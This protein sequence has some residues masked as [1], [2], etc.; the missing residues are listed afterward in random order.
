MTLT[1]NDIQEAL[2]TEPTVRCMGPGPTICLRPKPMQR[3]G[4]STHD[5]IPEQRCAKPRLNESMLQSPMQSCT[6]SN[7]MRQANPD[8]FRLQYMRSMLLV[9]PSGLYGS[10]PP[11]T[12]IATL[13][14]F[15]LNRCSG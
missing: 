6:L 3:V 1:M 12:H 4:L 10:T 7:D 13:P 5:D 8:I 9:I 15:L 2:N 11:I 14:R